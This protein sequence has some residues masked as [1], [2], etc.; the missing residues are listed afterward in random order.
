MQKIPT[1]PLLDNGHLRASGI[2]RTDYSNGDLRSLSN[3][4]LL[5]LVNDHL[6][7][8]DATVLAL[9]C[10]KLYG[11]VIWARQKPLRLMCP[12]RALPPPFSVAHDQVRAD[13]HPYEHCAFFGHQLRG[14][15]GPKHIYCAAPGQPVM[16]RIFPRKHAKAY[17]GHFWHGIID[18][19]CFGSLIERAQELLRDGG[20]GPSYKKRN[21]Y[22]RAVQKMLREIR[23]PEIIVWYHPRWGYGGFNDLGSVSD[24]RYSMMNRM[25]WTLG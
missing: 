23:L 16:R 13:D 2:F 6:S 10:R 20:V 11:A 22:L 18:C 5:T 15:F 25:G 17:D 24:E 19:E 21:Q 7:N 14:F 1:N 9:T 3:N 4:I 8:S 12:P